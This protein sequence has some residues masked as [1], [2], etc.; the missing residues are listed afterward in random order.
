MYR[1]GRWR[2]RVRPRCLDEVGQGWGKIDTI[3][4]ISRFRKER[5]IAHQQ[6]MKP[7]TDGVETDGYWDGVVQ[8]PRSNFG[9]RRDE[10]MDYYG[11]KF[12]NHYLYR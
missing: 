6:N 1:R 2:R 4:L 12:T 3:D 11:N 9:L 10:E 8:V 7:G 5:K